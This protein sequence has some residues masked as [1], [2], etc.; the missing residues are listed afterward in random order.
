MQIG[1]IGAPPATRLA[2]TSR[3]PSRRSDVLFD[4]GAAPVGVALVS[5]RDRTGAGLLLTSQWPLPSAPAG[6]C[7]T[8]CR[9]VRGSPRCGWLRPASAS[10]AYPAAQVAPSWIVVVHPSIP[11]AVTVTGKV[12]DLETGPA[13]RGRQPIPLHRSGLESVQGADRAITYRAAHLAHLLE[14]REL[15]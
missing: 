14:R 10:M 5:L 13:R 4:K 15:R 9:T 12:H 8:R 1:V 7:R 2:G 3:T 6:R 11:A